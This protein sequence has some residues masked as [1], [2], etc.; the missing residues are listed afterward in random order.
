MQG[1]FATITNV[2]FD[3][4]RIK[5]LT[6]LVR[7]EKDRLGGA[8]DLDGSTLWSGDPD[9]VSLRSTLLLG[10]RGMAAYAWHAY[11]LGKKDT[12][13]MAWFYKGLRALGAEHTVAEWLDLL[14]EFGQVN[15]GCMALLVRPIPRPLAI[16]S[17][18]K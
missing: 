2:N 8:D 4:A 14:M 11:V 10:L 13:V 12:D 3:E 7:Q 18:P 1:L 15:L 17:R 5:E 9:I 6:A 16:P